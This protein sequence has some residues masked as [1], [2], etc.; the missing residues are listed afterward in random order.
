MIFYFFNIILKIYTS[1][2]MKLRHVQQEALS[3]RHVIIAY[4]K[5]KL[6]VTVKNNNT[7]LKRKAS[8]I[9]TNRRNKEI[10]ITAIQI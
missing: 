3:K 8:K 10:Y 9:D 2:P 6:N 4:V 1:F 5:E 7:E